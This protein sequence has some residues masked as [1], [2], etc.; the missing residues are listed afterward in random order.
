[1]PFDGAAGRYWLNGKPT[2]LDPK[3]RSGKALEVTLAK[4]WNRL[5]VKISTADGLGKNY[6]GRWLSKWLVAAYLTPVA[7]VSYETRTSHG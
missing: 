4:G 5:L 3:S 6:D 7:P 1:V 2:D